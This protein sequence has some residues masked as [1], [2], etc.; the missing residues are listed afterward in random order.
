MMNL[1]E[2]KSFDDVMDMID[3]RII[4]EH[5]IERR[6]P[7]KRKK[8]KL[9]AQR[10][11]NGFSEDPHLRPQRPLNPIRSAFRERTL[12]A[13]KLKQGRVLFNFMDPFADIGGK[14]IKT[15]VL[16][17]LAVY[18]ANAK[19]ILTEGMFY[20]VL[21][22]ISANIFH[23]LPPH[24]RNEGERKDNVSVEEVCW[25]HL[26]LVYEVFYCFVHHSGFE[27]AYAQVYM[28][29]KF[30]MK[31]I[32]L[33]DTEIEPERY[34]LA[35]V[36]SRIF[37]KCPKR[38]QFI[39][40]TIIDTFLAHI[41]EGKEFN[42]ISELLQIFQLVIMEFDTTL[43]YEY[44]ELLMRVLL[45]LHINPLL[46][47]YHINLSSCVILFIKKFSVLTENIIKQLLLFW[48]RTSTEKQVIFL[49]EIDTILQLIE[50][51]E[52]Q[53]IQ[54]ILFRHL[55]KCANSPHMLVSKH[56]LRILRSA[57]VRVLVEQSNV[58]ILPI[59]VPA[60]Y[61]AT[62]THWNEFIVWLAMDVLKE[63]L[64]WVGYSF[65]Q[66]TYQ[67]HKELWKALHR[68]A[69][70]A[71]NDEGRASPTTPPSFI[72]MN[73]AL[74]E[75]LLA[76]YTERQ[77]E[78]DIQESRTRFMSQYTTKGGPK[79][80]L[81]PLDDTTS[82]S[83]SSVDTIFSEIANSSV[84]VQSQVQEDAEQNQS[85]EKEEQQQFQHDQQQE[86]QEQQQGEEER[87]KH[88]EE[89]QEDDEEEEYDEDD[90]D[91][92]EEDEDGEEEDDDEDL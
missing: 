70:N 78:R 72:Q 82:S 29:E 38:R 77:L 19:G 36:L 39:K 75:E 71:D 53:G 7:M 45:P 73:S 68:A 14:A 56:A 11:G 5:P 13:R 2:T 87:E 9:P 50:L 81:V 22:M 90:D 25:E 62:K 58:C 66:L 69:A 74:F 83:D 51:R 18:L 8:N 84:V 20:E 91:E 86:Q 10:Y 61:Q 21:G 55:G 48:P 65:Y 24:Q 6:S 34:T 28:D 4:E 49:E 67:D 79:L 88:Q 43:K 32:R 92:E 33:F 59:I 23:P 16:S 12:F 80:S 44:F 47:I 26:M 46:C 3:L 60:L 85:M 76:E 63:Y 52:F 15:G 41:Y 35:N 40:K 1:D 37:K 27:R 42:G 89:E 64:Q 57:R 30:L 17:N 31:L 54:K